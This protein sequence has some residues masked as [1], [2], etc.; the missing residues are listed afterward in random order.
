MKHTTNGT[1]TAMRIRHDDHEHEVFL[2]D[3]GTLDTVITV[4]GIDVRYGETDEY[5]DADG[6]MTRRGLR[7]LAIDACEWTTGRC[8][9]RCSIRPPSCRRSRAPL[10][11]S[12]DGA[13]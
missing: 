8:P 9:S 13:A 5:R 4:D 11:R 1:E 6:A 12:G 2:G 7:A 3:D 10:W